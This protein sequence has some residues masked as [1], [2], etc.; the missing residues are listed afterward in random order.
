MQTSANII[1]I[2]DIRR[3]SVARDIMA[4]DARGFFRLCLIAGRYFFVSLA[5]FTIL[6][7][8][9]ASFVA[10][11][12][13]KVDVRAEIGRIDAPIINHFGGEFTEPVSVMVTSPDSDA[14]FVYYI[15]LAGDDPGAVPDPTCG[16]ALGGPN[17]QGPITISF[18]SVAKA[19]ACLGDTP[20]S[21]HGEVTVETYTFVEPQS[22][23]VVLLEIPTEAEENEDNSVDE[24]EATETVL[25]ETQAESTSQEL[26]ESESPEMVSEEPVSEEPVVEE[27]IPEET[28]E[29]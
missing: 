20:E 1:V 29:E 9:L 23:N 4:R 18:N 27:A 12:A 22:E 17:P 28:T 26:T 3:V 21:P 8:D 15:I 7:P 6:L 24:P 10:F 25:E 5:A 13:H 11:E 14:N 2:K 19:V 16:S